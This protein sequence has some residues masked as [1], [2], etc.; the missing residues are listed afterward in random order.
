MIFSVKIRTIFNL[1]II[2][3]LSYNICFSKDD[4]IH[5]Y[6]PTISECIII[7]GHQDDLID[8]LHDYYDQIQPAW[9]AIPQYVKSINLQEEKIR[10]NKQLVLRISGEYSNHIFK[11]IIK[12]KKEKRG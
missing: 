7:N 12:G 4:V 6:H 5:E 3:L 1:L 10:K 11:K 2:S 9:R 8:F